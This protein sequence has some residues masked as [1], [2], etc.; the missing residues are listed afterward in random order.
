[1]AK[2]KVRMRVQVQIKPVLVC[3]CRYS[4]AGELLLCVC[5]CVC[6]CV[7]ERER[8]RETG[9]IQYTFLWASAGG[10]KRWSGKQTTHHHISEDIIPLCVS[11]HQATFK[12]KNQEAP[13]P[14]ECHAST[15]TNTNI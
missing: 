2:K 9:V 8:E 14:P 3:M 6:V 1:M 4:G 15:F 10:A 12:K 13:T 11:S 5:V 7:R